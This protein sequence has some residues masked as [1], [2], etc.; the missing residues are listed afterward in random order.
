MNPQPHF[1]SQSEP[2]VRVRP[3]TADEGLAVR[4]ILDGAMLRTGDLEAQID[5]G[6]VLVAV[7]DDRVLGALVAEPR[8][9]GAHITAVA[10]RRQRRNCGIGTALVE[11]ATARLGRLTATFDERVRPFYESLG[12]ALQRID[13]K[14]WRGVRS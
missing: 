1:H 4:R 7:D 5:A 9:N 2:S 6:Q 12:F 14:R 11:A 13:D 10:V 8:A 3:A